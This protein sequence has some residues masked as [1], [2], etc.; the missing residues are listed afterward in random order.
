M[1]PSR[2]LMLGVSGPELTPAE[3][4]LYRRIQ[5]GGF[6]LFTRNA[7]GSYLDILKEVSFNREMSRWL[8]FENNKAL[9]YQVSIQVISG[10]FSSANGTNNYY[11]GQLLS[12]TKKTGRAAISSQMRI[13]RGR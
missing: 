12:S 13:T 2:L 11:S 5:P 7:F 9:Q 3:A 4:A 8:T 6:V 10:S 1:S